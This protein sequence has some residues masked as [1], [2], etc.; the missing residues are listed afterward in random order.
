[1]QMIFEEYVSDKHP[2]LSL[3]IDDN[4]DKNVILKI[5]WFIK[6]FLILFHFTGLVYS[7]KIINL[8]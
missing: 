2:L 4:K 7:P 5:F 3:L 1:M 8:V 6:L